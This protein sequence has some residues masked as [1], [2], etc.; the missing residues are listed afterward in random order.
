MEENDVIGMEETQIEDQLT[1]EQETAQQSEGFEINTSTTDTVENLTVPKLEPIK[2]DEDIYNPQTSH[3]VNTEE[4]QDLGSCDCRSECKYNTG[5][6]WKSSD[7][8]YS[9]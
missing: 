8:G 9:D 1:F 3:S 5:K 7:Y 4:E 6:T 2:T